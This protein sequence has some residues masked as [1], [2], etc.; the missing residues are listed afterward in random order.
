MSKSLLRVGGIIAVLS[1]AA[2][3]PVD[4]GISN[5]DQSEPSV[6]VTGIT[7][8]F[9]KTL[10]WEMGQTKA[11]KQ[12]KEFGY[13]KADPLE[14]LDRRCQVVGQFG[15]DSEAVTQKYICRK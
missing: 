8:M 6:S 11:T 2:C 7:N 9:Q 5:I 10:D 3:A 4:M 13:A 12:C 1:I 15:C 14:F